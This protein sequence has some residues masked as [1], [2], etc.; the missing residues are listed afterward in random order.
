MVLDL[1]CAG[2]CYLATIMG[3]IARIA[4]ATFFFG[5]REPEVTAARARLEG[6][7]TG[8][9]R[10]FPELR[11]WCAATWSST[12]LSPFR[13]ALDLDRQAAN[14]VCLD[15]FLQARFVRECLL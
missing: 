2:L 8:V 4:L 5:R 1:T 7:E 6:V 9:G 15:V 3:S 11:R 14:L 13:F 12:L 10:H